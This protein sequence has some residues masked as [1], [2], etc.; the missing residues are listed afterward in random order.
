MDGA[1][2]A[3]ERRQPL[4]DGPKRLL[5]LPRRRAVTPRGRRGRR[6]RLCHEGPWG[7]RNRKGRD[8]EPLCGVIESLSAA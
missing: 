8:R 2:L 1:Q 7:G 5:D 4:L 3:L 6:S